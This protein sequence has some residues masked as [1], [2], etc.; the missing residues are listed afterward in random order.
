[1][2]FVGILIDLAVFLRYSGENAF[3]NELAVLN[4]LSGSFQLLVW[5]LLKESPFLILLFQRIIYIFEAGTHCKA[6]AGLQV[7]TR[8]V[9]LLR[10]EIVNT[11]LCSSWRV[12]IHSYGVGRY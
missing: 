9:R 10:A 11:L 5:S 6:Q 12:L 8:C 3:L 2:R 1:M 7:I 4:I